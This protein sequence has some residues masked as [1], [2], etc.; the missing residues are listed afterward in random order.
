M[1]YERIIMHR[2]NVL[3]GIKKFVIN[4]REKIAHRRE[5]SIWSWREKSNLALVRS[6]LRALDAEEIYARDVGLLTQNSMADP[7]RTV[8]FTV[9]GGKSVEITAKNWGFQNNAEVSSNGEQNQSAPRDV[10]VR[11]DS[12]TYLVHKESDGKFSVAIRRSGG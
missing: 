2:P 11:S 3:S 4:K 5:E 6:Q 10:W 9:A 8:K 7:A 1:Q 12:G